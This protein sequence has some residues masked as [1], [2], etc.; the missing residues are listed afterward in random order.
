MEV[1][2]KSAA[3][4]SRAAPVAIE[5]HLS[6]RDLLDSGL[7]TR[8]HGAR[9]RRG[10]VVVA[11]GSLI[12]NGIL[13][14]RAF[15]MPTEFRN[16]GQRGSLYIRLN[17]GSTAMKVSPPGSEASLDL[18]SHSKARSASPRQAYAQAMS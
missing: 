17:F 10:Y 12:A 5:D 13:S 2:A 8:P 6:A 7:A 18:F 1:A 9:D 3:G 14:S 16:S 15:D 4:A 11:P